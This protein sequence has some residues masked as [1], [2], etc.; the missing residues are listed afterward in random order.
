MAKIEHGLRSHMKTEVLD[1]YSAICPK[2]SARHGE[3]KKG[4]RSLDLVYCGRCLGQQAALLQLPKKVWKSDW[5]AG[6]R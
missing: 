6:G 4:A 3:N 1:G 2:C 5:R